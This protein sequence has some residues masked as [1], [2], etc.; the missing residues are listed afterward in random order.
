MSTR[1]INVGCATY[2]ERGF[3]NIDINPRHNPDIV[4]DVRR[5]LPFDGSSCAEVRTSHVLEHLPNDDVLFLVGEIYRVLAPGG[6]WS[7]TVPLG[8]TGDLDHKM[9]FTEDSFNSLLRPENADYFQLNM[10][11]EEVEGSRGI[12]QEKRSHV[13]S[14]NL[15]LRA[16]K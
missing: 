3:T 12:T 9:L 13:R 15:Q 16:V 1:R 10:R 14:F 2:K 8:N 5:G 4:R 7:I 11:W 6:I